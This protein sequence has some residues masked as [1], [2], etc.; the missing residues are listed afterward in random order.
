M[1]S[2]LWYGVACTGAS[3]NADASPGPSG[4]A[5]NAG[6]GDGGA[7]EAVPESLAFTP[8]STLKLSPKQTRELTLTTTP[9]GR[10]RVRFALLGSGSDSAPGDAALDSSEVDTDNDGIAHV[11]LTAPSTPTTFSVRAS[12]A[13]RVQTLI[14]VSVSQRGYTTLRVLPSYS[15]RRS[16]TEWTATATA[17]PGA[18]C[19]KLSGNPPP[20]GNLSA[21]A[22]PGKP[23]Y[24]EQVPIGVDVA[25]TLRA[26]HYIGG[27]A[28]QAA[29]AE[30][31]GNQVLVYASDR[32]L[33]L[34]ATQLD[35]SFGPSDT[36]PDFDNAMKTTATLAAA[37]F[38]DTAGDDVSALLDAMLDVTPAVDRDGFSEARSD[39]AWDAA[40]SRAFGKGAARRL[41]EPVERWLNAGL[42]TFNA[43]DT[44]SGRLR[45]EGDNALFS[46]TLVAGLEPMNAGFPSSFQAT[47]SADS[48]DTLL[49]GTELTWLPS[50]LV[51]A[52]AGAQA[53]LEV[54][55]A[56]TAEDALAQTVDCELV[57]RTLLATSGNAGT[58]YPECDER[59]VS[60]ACVSA[61]AAIW[62]RLRDASGSA[63]AALSITATGMA[64]VGENAEIASLTG[65]WVGQLVS[66]AGTAAAS[67]SLSAVSSSR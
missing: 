54:R 66:A 21:S 64:R 10:F 29:L 32:P 55:T 44:F 52:L 43:P 7:L 27:C 60:Q 47:W 8:A 23:L 41:R 59:C 36:R 62:K 35:L 53:L 37:A 38:P 20:D 57:T 12:V 48:S 42:L 13:S 17:K 26:G 40:L 65:A 24:L 16:I 63:T 4:G 28:N 14:G 56:A 61:V 6:G 58:I 9:A 49:L 18:N 34:R 2:S 22:A 25:V 46:L 67:G 50:R 5:F 45:A 51:A 11:I 1:A 31:D 33:N 19:N 30:G 15:G 39:L 3:A